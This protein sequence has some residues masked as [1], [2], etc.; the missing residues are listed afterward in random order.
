MPMQRLLALLWDV[1]GTLADTEL[2]GHRPAFNQAFAQAGLPWRWN[3]ESYRR[4]LVVA[5]GR[6]R[7]AAF[8]TRMEG[9]PSDPPRIEALQAAKQVAYQDLVVGGAIRPRPGVVRIM[10]AAAA[11]GI[12]QAVVT[13]SSRRAVEA[14]ASSCLPELN[15]CCA[16]W[17][18]GEDVTFK[19]PHPQA[20]GL[21][22]SQLQDRGVA[23]APDLAQQVLVIED[24]IQGLRAATAAGLTTLISRSSSS[25]H[26]PLVALGSAVAICDGL[27]DGGT[28][29]TVQSGPPCPGGQ[30]TLD[31]L[32]RLLQS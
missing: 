23:S 5:G 21:A 14:L 13:T 2:Q 1:D 17:I 24:S 32:E 15:Q 4:Q 31:W 29:M 20:Y 7:M 6:E 26:E 11:A 18:C 12:T 28:P 9:H 10:R 19:K 27:G 8:L 25:T 22:L 30:A 16:F 3:P